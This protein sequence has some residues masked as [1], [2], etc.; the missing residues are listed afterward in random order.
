MIEAVCDSGIAS[1][2]VE[3][4]GKLVAGTVTTPFSTTTEDVFGH[5]TAMASIIA[6]RRNN[7]VVASGLAPGCRVMPVEVSS[8]Q[9]LYT[10]F[11][12]SAGS[13]EPP[14]R[15]RARS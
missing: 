15:A 7:G 13:S 3:L 14:M 5:G 8:D 4:Q 6:A 10:N 2:P 1:G 12:V 11:E 9:G